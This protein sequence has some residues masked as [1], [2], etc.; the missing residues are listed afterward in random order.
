MP[1]TLAVAK[2]NV[3]MVGL[4]LKTGKVNIDLNTRNHQTLF[5]YASQIADSAHRNSIAEVADFAAG[6]DGLSTTPQLIAKWATQYPSY[7][8]LRQLRNYA[9]ER[10][11][12][13]NSHKSGYSDRRG[14]LR[15]FRNTL[16]IKLLIL[17]VTGV[18]PIRK[19]EP[20]EPRELR[21]S[22]EQQNVNLS[23]LEP[24]TSIIARDRQIA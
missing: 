4:L 3:A 1:I 9:V 18:G 13:F 24:G 23:V 14:K 8:V 2:S 16:A 20:R 21:E 17:T 5:E 22:R 11:L 6:L 10:N 15:E 19:D 7:A 12:K